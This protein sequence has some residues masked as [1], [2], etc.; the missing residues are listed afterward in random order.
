MPVSTSRYF[1]S[2]VS[3]PTSDNR[4]AGQELEGGEPQF[5]L[6]SGEE[7]FWSEPRACRVLGATSVDGPP[8]EVLVI[9]IEPPAIGQAF[10]LGGEDVEVLAVSPAHADK[11]LSP[12]PELPM[13][14]HI[15]LLD[16]LWSG[17][18]DRLSRQDLRLVGRGRLVAE[19]EQAEA[20]DSSMQA[21]HGPRV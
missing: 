3:I 9:A 6:T 21:M 13:D 17:P 1:G 15:L 8:R 5:W 2:R 11:S 14:V 18:A 20:L 19:R 7:V 16:K 4:S 10:G 12:R